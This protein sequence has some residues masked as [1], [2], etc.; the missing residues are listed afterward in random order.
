MRAPNR[1]NRTEFAG[2]RGALAVVAVLAFVAVATILAWLLA[3]ALLRGRLETE[4]RRRLGPEARF[5]S[6]AIDARGLT[7]TDLDTGDL[8]RGVSVLVEETRIDVFPPLLLWRPL[9]AIRGV[10]V[11]GPQVRARLP[12][13]ASIDVPDTGKGP[14]SDPTSQ[15][16]AAAVGPAEASELLSPDAAGETATGR[17]SRAEPRI[18]LERAQSAVQRVVR[19]MA[20]GATV[21]VTDG[22]VVAVAAALPGNQAPTEHVLISDL[23][24]ELTRAEEETLRTAGHGATPDGS[25]DWALDLVPGELRAEGVVKAADLPLA[26]LVPVPRAWPWHDPLAA[27]LDGRLELRSHA[28]REAVVVADGW[29]QV[30][31]LAIEAAELH[32]GPLRGLGIRLTGSSAWLPVERRL[33]LHEARVALGESQ[34]E[35]GVTG[36]LVLRDDRLEIEAEAS[37]PESPCRLALAMIPAPVLAGIE[38]FDWSGTIGGRVEAHI[39]SADPAAAR[40]HFAIEDRCRFVSVPEEA[41]VERLRGPFLHAVRTGDGIVSE[42]LVGP[43]APGWVP[44]ERISPFLSHAVLAHE[45][46]AFFRHRGFAPWAIETALQNNLRAGRFAYGAST[47]SMQL[48]KNL[49]LQRDKTLARKV[50]EVLLTWWLESALEKREIL[51]LY[52]N[53]IE[54]GPGIYGIGAASER[55]FGRRPGELSPAESAFLATLLP[56]PSS[57]H[58]QFVAGELGPGTRQQMRFLLERMHERERIDE[59]ALRHGLAE[60]E[61]FEFRRGERRPERRVLV[62]SAA[63]LEI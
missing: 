6:L 37:L 59:A 40:L 44:L 45:D 1:P 34:V 31:D 47:I 19:R 36:S 30:R 13:A 46:A 38:D 3:P 7:I 33:E 41:R 60:L 63:P 9:G 28:D 21:L 18:A 26:A 54:Y 5:A 56:A 17:T 10:R 11:E 52:L 51:A 16:A 24:F 42:R 55:Y 39:D 20:R 61:S 12:S 25:V 29:L 50:R 14:A 4:L 58:R 48:A 2:R 32:E 53:V 35:V 27:R 62:G 49:F 23:V 15:E 22:S 8:G 57:Y 43:G